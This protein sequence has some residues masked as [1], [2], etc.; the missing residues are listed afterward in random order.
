MVGAGMM[1]YRYGWGTYAVAAVVVLW[2]LCC[3]CCWVTVTVW[4]IVLFSWDAGQLID[5]EIILL[6]CEMFWTGADLDY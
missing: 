4:E 1:V 3:C 2:M 5:D 6:L